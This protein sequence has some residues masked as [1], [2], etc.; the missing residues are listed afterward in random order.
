MDFVIRSKKFVFQNEKYVLLRM[1]TSTFTL[2]HVD[3]TSP[4]SYENII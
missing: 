4:E 1:L 3:N 2:I